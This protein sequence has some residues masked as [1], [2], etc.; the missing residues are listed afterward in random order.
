MERV[1]TVKEVQEIFKRENLDRVNEISDR[2]VSLNSGF[3]VNYG[4]RFIDL[5]IAIPVLVL[6]APINFLLACIT[7]VDVGVPVIFRQKRTGKDGKP[8]TL[9]K[10]R[11]MR[12][13]TDE[14][15]NLLPPSQRVT[16]FGKFVRTT[17][18]DELLNF[19]NVLKGDMSI[20]GPR[21]LPS[22]FDPYYS[23][24]HKKRWLVRPGLECPSLYQENGDIRHYDK[25]LD[26]DVWYVENVSLI[27]DFKLMIRLVKMVF[28]KSQRKYHAVVDGGDF[29]GY[30]KNGRAINYKT[31]ISIINHE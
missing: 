19:W 28:N 24:Y 12:N 22:S 9:I 31:G 15:G 8:F 16:K 30:D 4:K 7:L 27:T 2:D 5:C 1:L 29:V 14:T 26:N 18:L 10:F 6:T 17:S 21:P 13:T 11:N 3:Y 20:I 23:E 25:Q